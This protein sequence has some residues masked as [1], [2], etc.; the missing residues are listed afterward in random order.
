MTLAITAVTLSCAVI[1]LAGLIGRKKYQHI[2]LLSWLLL[3]LLSLYLISLRSPMFTDRYLIWAAP[4][5]YILIAAGLSWIGTVRNAFMWSM[6]CLLV[7]ST[8][9]GLYAQAAYP[10]KPQYKSAAAYIV[11]HSTVDDLLLFQIP[12]N[13]RVF[14]FYTQN[15]VFDQ[16]EAPYTNWKLEDGTYQVGE[17]YV[18]QE[19]GQITNV[20]NRIWLVYS[21]VKLWDERELV[22]QWLDARWRLFD[23]QTYQGV[24]L[25]AYQRK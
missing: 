6:G 18:H 17:A 7:L 2:K 25:Y 10:I 9:P 24:T 1:G 21:E 14:E 5:F 13:T 19:M 20:Y 23:E 22:K 8:V 4:A 3:P 12:Y 16:A 15:Q 11:R